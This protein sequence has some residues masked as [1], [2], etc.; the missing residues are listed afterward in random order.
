MMFAPSG[1]RAVPASL[2]CLI[3]VQVKLMAMT[4]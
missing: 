4:Q 2:Y 1:D 3:R